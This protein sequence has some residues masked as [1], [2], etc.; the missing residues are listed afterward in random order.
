VSAAAH[1]RDNARVNRTRLTMPPKR[2]VPAIKRADPR[3]DPRY[4]R[5][6]KKLNADSAKLKKHPPAR[7]KA[8]EPAKAAKGPPDEKRAGAQANQVDRIEGAETKKPETSSFLAILQAEIAKAMPK[9]LGDTEKFMKGGSSGELKGGLKGNVDA[10]KNAATGDLKQT[11]HESPNEAGVVAK[12]VTPIAP[13]PATPA[14]EVDAAAAMP[15]PK[16][17]AEVSLDASKQDVAETMSKEKLTDKRLQEANDPRFSAV[18]PAKNAVNKHALTGPAK[19]RGAEAGTLAGTASNAV[20]VARKGVGVLLNTKSGSQTKMRSQQEKQK[21]KEEDELKTFTAFVST[22]FESAKKQVDRRLEQLETKVNDLFDRGVDTALENLKNYVEDQLLKYKLKRYLLFPGGALLWLKDQI[23]DLPEEV[24]RFYEAGRRRFTTE[25]NTLAV[26]VANLVES[27]LAAAKT[28]VKRAQAKITRAQSRLSPGVQARAAEVTSQFNEKFAELES[29]IEDKKQQLAEG[30]AQK[31]KEA[32][33]KADEALKAI[34]D[35]NKGLVTKAKEKIGEVLKAL[36]EFKARLMGVL[37]KG[38]DTLDLIIAAPMQ[39]LSNLLA[40]IKG[41]FQAFVGNILKH[42]A[43]GFAKWLFGALAKAGLEI[44]S[45]LSIPSVLKLVLSVLGITYDRMRAKAVKLLGPTAV[46]VIEKLVS[47]LQ[48]LI[49]GGPAALWA[50]IKD[51]VGNLKDMVV[52]AIQDWII[53]TI[54]KKAV[55]KIVSMFNPAG[56]IVQAVLMIISVVRFVIERAAQIMEFVESVINSIHAI[57]TGAIGGAIKRVEQALANM[58]PILIGFLA[59]LV[60]L[61]GISEKIKGFIKKVQAKVDKAIDKMLAKVVTHIKKLFGAIK[62]GVKKLLNW[63]K[64][65]VPISAGTAKHTLMYEGTGKSAKLVVRSSPEPPPHFLESVAKQRDIKGPEKDVPIG[66][67]RSHEKDVTTIQ[68]ELEKYDANDKPATTDTENAN[69]AMTRLDGK[70]LMLAT[71]IVATLTKW[72]V[73]EGTITKIDIPRGT[74]T[75]T[76][77]A[78]IAEEHEKLKARAG[79]TQKELVKNKQDELINLRKG[80][81]RRHVVSSHNIATHYV[82]TLK[83][84]PWSEAKLL[85]EERSSIPMARTKVSGTVDETSIVAAA[86]ARYNKFFGYFRNIF[87]GDSKENSSIQQHLDKGHPEMADKLL[88]DHIDRIQREW[89]FDTSF[90]PSQRT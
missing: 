86:K 43:S 60:G 11:A 30:L 10:Q 24:N 50:Q 67:A 59:A 75:V 42:L 69:K 3:K 68:K 44:P 9:T 38:K 26:R 51:D 17:A 31:Y 89:A 29:G 20:S 23:M 55:A 21:Q 7:A 71:H 76:Q 88:Y 22:T 5:V 34:Q 8:A 82:A 81:A 61:G 15:A 53:T 83:G 27:Q 1:G 90:T 12:P 78:K 54:V 57:A 62:A 46:T 47:Y 80:L 25:M 65:K 32:F 64:K 4:Q 49:G 18:L 58:V 19:Y 63:W 48:T 74:F 28:D 14:P 6:V 87:I 36:A 41:G 37:R 33:D 2:A 52:G 70:L 16:P 84:K 39:F 72:K 40:A 85:I 66:V 79:Q 35:E 77:K 73:T 56:A 45:D 13:D